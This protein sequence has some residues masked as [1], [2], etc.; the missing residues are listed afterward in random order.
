[1]VLIAADDL[2]TALEQEEIAHLLDRAMSRIPDRMRQLLVEHY[3]EELPQAE[4]A[5]RRGIREETVAVQMHRGR[6]ALRDALVSAELRKQAA[7]LGLIADASVPWQ[8]THIWCP[9]CGRRRMMGKF[10]AGEDRTTDVNEFVL[11][12]P[13]CNAGP[14]AAPFTVMRLDDGARFSEV[15]RGIKGFKPALNRI[16]NLWLNYCRTALARGFAACLLCDKPVPVELT[17]PPDIA[18]AEGPPQPAFFLRCQRCETLCYAD[19]TML[20]LWQPEAQAFW[21]GH[22]RIRVLPGREVSAHG[23]TVAVLTR[24]ESVT[25][26]EVLDILTAK[27]TLQVIDILSGSR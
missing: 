10:N 21:R 19:V 15:L 18:G 3:V 22:P 26:S 12:C 16:S 14:D 2:D 13:D 25:T 24:I 4:I 1:V 20:G 7:E 23:G 8:E 11:R 27:D 17:I 6:K 9:M 5:A